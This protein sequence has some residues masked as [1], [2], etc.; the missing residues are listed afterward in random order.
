MEQAQAA[1]ELSMTSEACQ[2]M[3]A[4]IDMESALMLHGVPAIETVSAA[5]AVAV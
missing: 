3:F 4:L 5:T 1:S 2:P